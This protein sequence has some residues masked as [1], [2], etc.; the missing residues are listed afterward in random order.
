MKNTYFLIN[1]AIISIPFLLSF[2]PRVFFFKKWLC[3]FRSILIVG[4]IYVFWDV[5]ATVLGHWGFNHEYV[6]GIKAFG[7]PIEEILF[8]VTAPFSCLFLY[9]VICFFHKDKWLVLPQRLIQ[10]IISLALVLGLIFVGRDYTALSFLMLALFLFVAIKYFSSIVHTQNF[11]I[12]LGICYVPF[13]IFNGIL[14]SLPVVTYN[15]RAITG[16]RL[17]TIPAE[18]F[19]YNFAYLGFTLIA[20]K[21]F[22]FRKKI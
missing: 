9:E 11:W 19:L 14:T 22:C 3:V 6:S 13:S 1:L 12:Y 4:S 2:E 10:A 8:F 18:D 17:G 15:S 7:L 21:I 16:L 20:Y 5:C